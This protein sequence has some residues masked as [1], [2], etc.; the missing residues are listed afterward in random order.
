MVGTGTCDLFDAILFMSICGHALLK[1]RKSLELES[2]KKQDDNKRTDGR[3][4]TKLYDKNWRHEM[5]LLEL[6]SQKRDWC[7]LSIQR[8]GLD[9]GGRGVGYLVKWSDV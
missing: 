2:K 6:G 9:W 5:R 1:R 3:S 4:G 8:G 7:T